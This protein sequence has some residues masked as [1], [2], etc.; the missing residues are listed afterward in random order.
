MQFAMQQRYMSIKLRVEEKVEQVSS[1]RNDY[2]ATSNTSL[3]TVYNF[4]R[5]LK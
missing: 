1:F 5:N 3:P 4:P 2:V